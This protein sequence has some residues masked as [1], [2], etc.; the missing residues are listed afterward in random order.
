MKK[1]YLTLLSI[2]GILLGPNF[3]LNGLKLDRV[4]VS[5]DTHPNYYPFWPIVARAWKEVVGI[6]PT[7][8]LIAPPDFPID[9]SCGDVIRIDPIPGIPTAKQAQ[10]IRLLAP[11]LF[12]NEVCI[13]SDVDIIPLSKKYF[14][15]SIATIAEDKFVVYRDK[16]YDNRGSRYPMCYIAGKGY[17]FREIFNIDL[18]QSFQEAVTHIIQKWHHLNYGWETDEKV[19]RQYLHSWKKFHSHCVRLGHRVSGRVDRENWTYNPD[20]VIKHEY[21]DAHFPRPYI[22]YKNEIDELI[23]LLLH[24]NF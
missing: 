6:Q 15:N 21:I 4:I 17:I 16:A 23:S 19:L 7:L 24:P 13:V 8:I 12:E 5:S 2:T 10:V 9:T 3:Y 11:A 20:L 14:T 1:R 22:K 18:K